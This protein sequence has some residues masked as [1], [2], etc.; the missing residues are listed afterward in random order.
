[1]IGVGGASSG[2]LITVVSFSGRA[3]GGIRAVALTK[4]GALG[5]SIPSLCGGELKLGSLMIVGLGVR[6]VSDVITVPMKGDGTTVGCGVSRSA[7]VLGIVPGEISGTMGIGTSTGVG[8]GRR[9]CRD[10]LGGVN[11]TVTGMVG[12]FGCD[13]VRL[14]GGEGPNRMN[15]GCLGSA[16]GGGIRGSGPMLITSWFE[17]R[18]RAIIKNAVNRDYIKSTF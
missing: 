14:G 10:R 8:G 17:I 18:P 13:L 4:A 7:P 9:C 15:T 2:T 11:R 3:G 6:L 12:T 16:R 1:M 5:G